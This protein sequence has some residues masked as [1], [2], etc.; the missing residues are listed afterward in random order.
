VDELADVG[1]AML[2]GMNPVSMMV[3]SGFLW[4]RVKVSLERREGGWQADLD[5]FY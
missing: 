4:S 3:T 5:I 1:V 2:D